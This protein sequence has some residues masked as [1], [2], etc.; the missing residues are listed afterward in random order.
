VLYNGIIDFNRSVGRR[1]PA[2]VSL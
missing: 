2:G 1:G